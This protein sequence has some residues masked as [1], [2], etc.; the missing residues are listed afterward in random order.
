MTLAISLA[1]LAG[2]LFAITNVIDKVIVSKHITKPILL[3]IFGEYIVPVIGL[4]LLPFTAAV[5][6]PHLLIM[7][8]LVEEHGLILMI[9]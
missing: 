6:A 2:F 3:T 9:F 7:M 4:G 5:S 8:L 1:I